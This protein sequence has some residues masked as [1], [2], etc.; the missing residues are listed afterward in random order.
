[1]LTYTILN[2]KIVIKK[3]IGSI[4][5]QQYD[6]ICEIIYEKN[7]HLGKEIK[8]YIIKFYKLKE[9]IKKGKNIDDLPF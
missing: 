7:N 9:K 2:L 1:M 3:T 8:R 4:T 5:K 6:E